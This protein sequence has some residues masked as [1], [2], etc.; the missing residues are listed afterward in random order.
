MWSNS[1]NRELSGGN[2]SGRHTPIPHTCRCVGNEVFIGAMVMKELTFR[3][4][5]A[6]ESAMAER[7]RGGW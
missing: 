3:P 1:A 2:G 7:E 6:R 4:I 5:L